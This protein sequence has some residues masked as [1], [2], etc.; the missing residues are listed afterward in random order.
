MPP[1]EER[2]PR[3]RAAHW[4]RAM[5][6]WSYLLPAVV[7]AVPTRLAVDFVVWAASLLAR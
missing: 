4:S 7:F 1:A 5:N 6:P 3:P 2:T